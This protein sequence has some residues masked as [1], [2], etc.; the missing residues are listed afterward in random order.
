MRS[1]RSFEII[2][3]FAVLHAA[4][5]FL[6]RV[7]GV[8]DELTLTLL[9]I[10]M[11][12]LLCLRRGVNVEFT[13]AC[14]IVVNVVGYLLGTGS[15]VLIGRALASQPL[16]HACSSFL[17]TEALGW[18][19][20]GLVKL[21]RP[22]ESSGAPLRVRTPRVGLLL[23]AVGAIFSLRLAYMELLRGPLCSLERIYAMR[24]ALWSSSPALI[25]LLCANVIYVRSMRRDERRTAIKT[26]RLLLFLLAS[27]LVGSLAVGLQRLFSG[28][29]PAMQDLPPLLLVALVSEATLYSAV[30]IVDYALTARAGLQAERGRTHQAQFLYMKL[31]QQVNPHFLINSLNILDCLVCEERTAQASDFIHKLAGIYRYM[32]QNEQE[33]LVQMEQELAFVEKYVE[34]LQV[35]FEEG[36]RV[37]YD[38]APEARKRNVVPCSMQLL[39]ENAIK[40]NVVDAAE[41]LTIRIEATADCVSVSNNLRPRL[42]AAPSTHVGLEYIRRQ[43]LDLADIPIEIRRTAE[44]YC[45]TLPL[46]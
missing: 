33:P 20:V 16:V 41:P 43:Y 31:K 36:F 11:I 19:V 46:L 15:A 34:L 38:I 35:R 5:A 10:L 42:S 22:T 6:C 32:L 28:A 8:D 7:G 24:D 29:P 18:G 23:L 45:V 17:T 1:L 2:H 13:A 4:V 3:L 39:V 9:S 14:I 21:F 27:A 44:S 12:V 26:L 25:I 30:F 37:E 40:H